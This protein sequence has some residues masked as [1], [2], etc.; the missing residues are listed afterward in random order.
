MS[1]K[2]QLTRHYI[3]VLKSFSS[4]FW[5]FWRHDIVDYESKL[6]SYQP[7]GPST[8]RFALLILITY[9]QF[10]DPSITRVCYNDSSSPRFTQHWPMVSIPVFR[11][12]TKMVK[13][14]HLCHILGLSSRTPLTHH[15]NWN[16]VKNWKPFQGVNWI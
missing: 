2:K 6:T 1:E 12:F 11:G 3:V 15:D 13:V 16:T 5:L 14:Q 10:L 7:C 8:G 9:V 4:F